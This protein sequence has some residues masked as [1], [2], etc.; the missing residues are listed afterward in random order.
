MMPL[1]S[2]SLM[3]ATPTAIGDGWSRSNSDW[4]RSLA[5]SPIFAVLSPS[6]RA[7]LV[8]RGSVTNLAVGA[9]LFSAGDPPGAAYLVILGELKIALERAD[10]GEVWLAKASAGEV[11]GDL[12]LLDGLG[13][14][15]DVTATRNTRLLRLGREAVLEALAD[16][17]A[18]AL[19]LLAHL[20][21]RLRHT[22]SRVE[23]AAAFD[24]GARL[25][26]VLLGTPAGV[27]TDSQSDLARLIGA[28][29]ESVNRKLGEWRS[30]GL[31]TI[32]PSG[33]RVLAP[34]RLK[35]VAQV[36]H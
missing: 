18:A 25:A 11:V 35:A 28:A 1:K 31:V 10:G 6:A 23:E 13:R 7:R 26:R 32:R 12:A 17:P 19:E 4:S 5:R 15:A 30:A 33:I 16:E 20:A 34:E 9:R 3:T 24:L 22:N 2:E 8:E 14:S 27:F 29:R 21:R 36:N